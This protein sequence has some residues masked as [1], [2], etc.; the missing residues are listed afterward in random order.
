MF[1]NCRICKTNT[2]EEVINLGNMFLSGRFPNKSESVNSYQVALT[3]CSSCNLVQLGHEYPL[4]EMYGDF[5]GYESSLN[6]SMVEHLKANISNLQNFLSKDG[7]VLDI[8]SN[9]GTSLSFYPDNV[10][11]IGVDPSGKRFVDKYPFNSILIPEFFDEE[12]VIKFNQSK[13]YFDII[14]SFAMFYDLPDPLKFAA[15]IEKLL[16]NEGVWCLEQ[17]YLPSMIKQNAFDTICHEHIEYYSFSDLKKIFDKVG[18]KALDVTLNETNGGSFK[19]LCCKKSSKHKPNLT[20]DEIINYENLFFSNKNIFEDFKTRIEN[21]KFDLR[22]III[23]LKNK[24]KKVYGL[25]ASTKGNILLQYFD[26]D[27]NLIDAIGEVNKSKFG[28]FTPGTD[29]PIVDQKEIL[30]EKNSC[31]IVLPWHFASF[32]KTSKI[33][34]DVHMIFPLPQIEII[35][36]KN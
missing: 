9:D 36:E 12:I 17:S 6:P 5:Y 3:K 20:V 25:G 18:L 22:E 8:G 2:L 1:T 13:K 30:Q 28:K 35:N 27:K 21:L 7:K 19:V 16:S 26:L 31:F 34:K 32:F 4:V 33:F 14:T 10:E 15:N 11:K 29:I 24:G 23:E